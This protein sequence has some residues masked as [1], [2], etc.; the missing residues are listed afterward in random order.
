MKK[1]LVIVYALILTV[2]IG[3]QQS[4][5]KNHSKLHINCVNCHTCGI[6]TKEDP[7]WVECP[8][9]KMITVYMKPEQTAE[10]IIIDQLSDRY[11]PVYFPH[12]LHA[13]MSDMQGGCVNCHHHNTLEEILQCSSCHESSR[14]RE[15]VSSPDLKGAYHR[16]C[17][18]CHREWSHET[19]CNW[20]HTLKKD[21]KGT[22]K[23]QFTKKISGKDHPVILEPTKILYETKSVKGKIVTFYHDDHTKKFEVTCTSCHKQES[24]IRCH[25]V[26]KSSNDLPKT[27]VAKKSFNEQHKKCISCHKDDNCNSCHHNK[28]IERFDHEKKSGWVLNKYHKALSCVKC[29]GS[30]ILYTKPD[31]NCISCH[32]T[33][34]NETFQHSVTDLQLDEMHSQLS[35]EDCHIEKNYAEKPSCDGCHDDYSFPKQ[36]PG[37][38][39]DK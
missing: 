19:G 4:P 21:F 2:G 20:C 27:V 23:E 35:C 17:M 6:P 26:N 12:K 3:A 32:K 39:V 7:C 22:Q 34:N 1:I 28:E 14:K 8:R 5:R 15:D 13:Q 29:H 31:N 37:K 38:L 24:C 33:W 16:Q 36:K 10:L 11:G 25:D 18:N 9:E 30:Q